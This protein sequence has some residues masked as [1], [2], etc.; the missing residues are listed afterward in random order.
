MLWEY[1]MRGIRTEI[2]VKNKNSECL[3]F[4]LESSIIR[5]FCVIQIIYI[6]SNGLTN[7]S[8]CLWRENFENYS[9]LVAS[10]IILNVCSFQR[11]YK[12]T[13]LYLIF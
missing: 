4:Y 9:R 7:E 13:F 1:A 8:L 5:Q 12:F 11:I 6:I 2:C 3:E 10:D